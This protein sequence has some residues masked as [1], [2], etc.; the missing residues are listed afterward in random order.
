MTR[1]AIAL[2]ATIVAFSLLYFV[3]REAAQQV[4]PRRPVPPQFFFNMLLLLL[5]VIFL[6]QIVNFFIAIL[7]STLLLPF[8]VLTRI[9]Y[10]AQDI[11]AVAANFLEP[12]VIS[13]LS[14]AWIPALIASLLYKWLLA[15]P[16]NAARRH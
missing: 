12:F 6:A 14:G 13:L 2:A 11:A 7:V 15:R 3:W 5:L 16:A 1:T 9:D 8:F 10:A 4:L